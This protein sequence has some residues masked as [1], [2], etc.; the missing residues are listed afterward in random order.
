MRDVQHGDT[1][2]VSSDEH[3]KASSP[4]TAGM[5]VKRFDEGMAHGQHTPL[6]A[7]P[8]PVKYTVGP[9]NSAGNFV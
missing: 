9:A 6:G 8:P 7:N 1:H 5:P 4:T 2:S 3:E